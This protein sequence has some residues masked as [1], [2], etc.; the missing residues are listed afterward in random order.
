[1]QHESQCYCCS[2]RLKRCNSYPSSNLHYIKQICGK[3]FVEAMPEMH[4]VP[5]CR[6]IPTIFLLVSVVWME[7]YIL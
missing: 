4:P 5:V 7:S 3:H 2:E 6:F 1:M